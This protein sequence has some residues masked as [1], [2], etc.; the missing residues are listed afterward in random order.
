MAK[1]LTFSVDREDDIVLARIKVLYPRM[2][3]S[4]LVNM[5]F[6]QWL[7]QKEKPVDSKLLKDL[8]E[9]INDHL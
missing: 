9:L 4:R 2:R 5:V 1:I 8:Q 6:R 7:E 3:F